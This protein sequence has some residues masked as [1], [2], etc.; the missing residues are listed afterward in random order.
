MRQTLYLLGRGALLAVL[1]LAWIAGDAWAQDRRVSGRVTEGGEPVPGANVQVKGTRT[2]TT[3]TAEGTY[4]INVGTGNPVLV[5]SAVGYTTREITVGSQTTVDVALESDVT[6]LNEVVVTGYTTDSKRETTGA[7]S[8]V[9]ARDLAITPSGNVEQQLQGRVAGVTVITNGQPGT[10]SQVRVRGF[11]SFGGNQPLYVVDGVP[12]SDQFNGTNFLSPDDIESTTVLK[13]ASSASLYGARA[14]GGVIVI[15]TKKGSRTARKLTVTYDGTFGITTPGEGQP[16][17]NPQQQADWTWQ[18]IRNTA[19]ALG[20]APD[21]SSVANGQYGSGATPVLP[22]YINIGGRAGITGTIDLAAERLKYN[23]NPEAGG[24]Y[25]VVAA[26]KAGTDWYGAITRNAPLIRNTLGFSGGTERSRYYIGFSQQNQAGILKNNDFARYTFRVNTEFDVLKKLRLG[27]NIQLTY[28]SVLGQGGGENGQGVPQDENDILTAFRMPPIIPIYDEFG[29][30]A[31]TAAKGF[32]N[33]RNPVAS[34]DGLQN[35]R[36]FNTSAFG[37]IYLEFDPI[38]GMTLRSSIGANFN[39]Y[40]FN[41]YDRRQYENSE[42]NASFGYNEGSGYGLNWTLTNTVQYKRRLGDA[43]SID[44]ILGQEALNTG[45]GRNINGNGINP[46]SQDVNYVTLSTVQGTGRQVSSGYGK[47]VNFN[48]F[49]GRA[50]YSFRDKYILTGVVRRDGSSRFGSTARYGVFPAVSAAWRISAE[51]FMR[52]LSFITDLKIRGGYGSMGNS[53]NVDP[54]N[55]YSLFGSTINSGYDITGSKSTVAPGFYRSRIGNP[56]AQWETATTSNIGIDGTFFNGKL[57]VVLD[58]WRKDN[59]GLLFQVPLPGVIGVVASSPSVNVAR[60]RN[61]GIDLLVTN[62]GKLTSDIGYEATLTGGF[63]QNIVQELAPGVPNFQ[64]GDFRGIVPVRIEPGQALSSFYG[65]KVLGL[66]ATAEEVKSAPA[67]QGAGVGRFRFADINGDNTVDAADRTFLGSPVPKFT[68]GLNFG[69][70]YKGFDLFAY[71]YTT[72]GNK[73]FNVS[74]WYTDFY[75][76]FTGAAISARVLDSWS[77]SNTSTDQPIFENI[78]NFSTNTQSNSWYVENGNYLR[79]QN[80]TLGYTLP[81][82]MLGSLGLERL[83]VFVQTTNLFTI[84]KYKGLDPGVGG[85]ADTNFGIDVGNY[86]VTRG[87]N[88]GLGITF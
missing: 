8:T 52:D 66:F 56:D 48:S 40:Y 1:V 71:F 84:S 67:Q 51:D 9:K 14:A 55:Q 22:D 17:L 21:F 28:Y 49:F 57:E 68:G 46:F 59:R 45:T 72:L 18:A 75:P 85:A 61:Q 13:D 12:L 43:H 30:Y 60:M 10:N 16:I 74:K 73:L 29:G 47:G 38:P 20:T 35:N 31:G 7:V 33:P 25:Q 82:K 64:V 83:R 58:I 24:I 81:S 6:A 63:L 62:R 4:S 32:N 65:Y 27:E 54:N 26:N 11:G 69:L 3:T 19:T 88:A 36:G 34:R 50:V 44:V 41:G 42:N 79:M 78:S 23:V 5:V 86:P 39:N 2:G 15:T 70:T 77:P 80:L 53:N 37:N 76:S 87:F